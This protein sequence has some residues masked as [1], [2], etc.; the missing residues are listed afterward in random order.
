LINLTTLE[1]FSLEDT[2]GLVKV[3][4]TFLMIAGS[5]KVQYFRGGELLLSQ[6]IDCENF[7]NF[8]FGK[9]HIAI[10]NS[11]GDLFLYSL[12][13]KLIEFKQKFRAFEEEI[14]DIKIIPIYDLVVVA[15]SERLKVF[16]IQNNEMIEK[17]ETYIPRKKI[18][19]IDYLFGKLIVGSKLE[20][21]V[22]NIEFVKPIINM[23]H[24][25]LENIN[26]NFEYFMDQF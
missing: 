13:E 20:F 2:N 3:N 25:K 18:T 8:D 6:T 5:K 7:T 22:Y 19:C 16:K 21:H 14:I 12:D 24:G 10:C 15:S 11:T 23:N 1:T 17:Y 26:F 9:Q 4:Q